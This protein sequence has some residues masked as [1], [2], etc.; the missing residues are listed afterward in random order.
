[1]KPQ[2]HDA[3]QRPAPPRLPLPP[4]NQQLLGKLI[5]QHGS[6]EGSGLSIIDTDEVWWMET[7]ASRHWAAVRV[8]NDTLL[9]AANQQRIQEIPLDDPDAAMYDAGLLDFIA[10]AQLPC[11]ASDANRT[12][13]LFAW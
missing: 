6:P 13:D 5:E 7:M 2:A 3:R 8:P 11:Q 9:V 12:L 4:T 10:A 1:M